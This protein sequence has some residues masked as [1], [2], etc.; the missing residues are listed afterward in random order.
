MKNFVKARDREASGLAFLLEKFSLISMEKLKVGIFDDLQIKNSMFDETL[1]EAELSTW[2]S[3]KSVVTNDLGNHRRVEYENEIKELLKSFRNSRQWMSVKLHF[4]WS[5]LDNFPKNCGDFSEKEG[6]LFHQ[7]IC[8]MGACCQGLW[9]VNFLVDY[10]WYLRR[11]AVA[12]ER[13]TK[14]LK[15]P[16]IHK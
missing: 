7:D 6:K 2:Q 1:S 10:S 12:A 8:I 15:R 3:Q 4:L 9:E 13:R 14:S 5:H 11:D 16:F